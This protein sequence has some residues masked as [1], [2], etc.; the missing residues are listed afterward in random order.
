MHWPSAFKPGGDLIPKDSNGKIQTDDVDFV[1]TWKALEK[2]Y[3]SG[4]AKAI[5]ISNFSQAEIERLLKETEVVSLP[6]GHLLGIA[7]E[8]WHA[9]VR[10]RY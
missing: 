1:D 8:M 3:K 9:W 6:C 2:V 5:G 10:G 7:I 4:K